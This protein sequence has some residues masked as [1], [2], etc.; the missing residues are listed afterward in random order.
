MKL[1]MP[2]GLIPGHIVLD[3]D[4]APPPNRGGG[5]PQ[6]SAHVRR[7]QTA[8]WIKMPLGMGVGLC[9][10]DFVLDADPP[11]PPHKGDKALPIFGPFLLWPNGWMDQDGT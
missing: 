9:S 11:P 10:G 4:P 5:G 6:L 3:G 8:G 7:G 1:G 2:V